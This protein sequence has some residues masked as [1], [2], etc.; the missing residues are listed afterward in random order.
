M[1]IDTATGTAGY[2]LKR[3][4]DRLSTKCRRLHLLERYY[5]GDHPLPEGDE[6]ARE[7]FRKFQR[8][9]RTNYCEL[10]ADSTRER[11]HILGFRTGGSKTDEADTEAWRVWQSNGLD[12]ASDAAHDNALQL[13]NGYVIA[14]PPA[15]GSDFATI[16]V[17]DPF[18]VILETD[19]VN[20]RRVRAA[21]KTWVDEVAKLRHAIV[22][23][24]AE[25]HY[26]FG[27]ATERTTDTSWSVEKPAAANTIGE[28]PVVA[29]TN[30]PNRTGEGRA[31]FEGILDV[32][33]R[34]NDTVL[35]R[36]VIT[37]MQAYR[38][39]WAKGITLTDENGDDVE[40]PFVP[41]VDLVWAVEDVDA[42]FG[43]FA[44]TNLD[45]I[46]NAIADDVKMLV[47]L[48]G[49][50]PHYIAGDLV[51]ASADAITAAESRLVAK[52]RN[53]QVGFGESWE[54]VMRLAFAW[55]GDPTRIGPDAEVLWKDPER[56]S[57]AQLA[58]AAVKA[59]EADVPWRQRMRDLGY[60]PQEIERM[61]AERAED[62]ALV[63]A[64][65]PPTITPPAAAPSTN[66]TQPAPANVPAG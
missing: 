58:D 19:P 14:G 66:G 25:I 44:E 18:Q 54:Q 51:N 3:L 48:T 33:D 15:D 10:V 36:L 24:P 60:T 35:N 65:A 59:K 16:T 64:F 4:D 62:A 43:D 27:P 55:M 41:G 22:Y 2:W 17:E 50:P 29:L 13:R 52:V 6:R 9:A 7:T 12:S 53:R 21:L 47:Q 42:Q 34:I 8:K 20:R 23:L 5:L 37:K 63:A 30:R 45:P 56:K 61:A 26:F 32:Q 49:L 39:R 11:L 46:R 1:T 38:Q 31:E 57:M 40:L 28:V